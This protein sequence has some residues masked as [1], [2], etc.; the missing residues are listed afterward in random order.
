MSLG[1][2]NI[3]GFSQPFDYLS[4]YNSTEST[5]L[6]MIL[7][8]MKLSHWSTLSW[9]LLEVSLVKLESSSLG[10]EVSPFTAT[11]RFYMRLY[12]ML[13][14][15]FLA[16]AWTDTSFGVDMMNPSVLKISF[17]L[18]WLIFWLRSVWIDNRTLQILKRM[19]SEADFMQ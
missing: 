12:A 6:S 2:A 9:L 8:W 18:S 13:K 1:A 19:G 11:S 10:V 16:A 3:G 5:M 4:K 14:I 7:A 17:R 15:D